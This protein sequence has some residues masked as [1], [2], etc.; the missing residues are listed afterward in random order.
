MAR[1][2]TTTVVLEAYDQILRTKALLL[3]HTEAFKKFLEQQ[4]EAISIH[5]VRQFLRVDE[6]T[7]KR[8]RNERRQ[9][10]QN[11]TTDDEQLAALVEQLCISY[12][13]EWQ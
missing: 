8:R 4:V 9:A 3:H 13:E 6:Y 1:P 7:S 12:P 2:P 11:L 5:D 10:V